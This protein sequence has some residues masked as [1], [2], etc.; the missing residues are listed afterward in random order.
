MPTHANCQ[1]IRA[2]ER[3]IRDIKNDLDKSKDP[4]LIEMATATNTLLEEI[5]RIANH[6]STTVLPLD[7]NTV[8]IDP[9]D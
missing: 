4:D 7:T 3:Q 6:H 5:Y 9:P 1:K 8:T 2:I